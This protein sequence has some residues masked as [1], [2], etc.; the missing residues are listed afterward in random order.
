MF[1]EELLRNDSPPRMRLKVSLRRKGEV[2]DARI[3]KDSFP[4][5]RLFVDV[6]LPQVFASSFSSLNGAKQSGTLSSVLKL[7]QLQHH[8]WQKG[9]VSCDR[10]FGQGLF[11]GRNKQNPVLFGHS[12][13]LAPQM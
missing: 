10:G 1:Y 8:R 9:L 12:W 7:D 6:K 2:T 4:A 5:K 13:K 3:D 11:A